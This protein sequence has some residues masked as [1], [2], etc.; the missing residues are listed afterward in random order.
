VIDFSV[1]NSLY[2]QLPEDSGIKLFR[3]DGL[4]IPFNLSWK[5]IGINLSGGADSTCL[6]TLLCKIIK[7]NSIKCEVHV[8]SYIRCWYTRPWQGPIA[9]DIYNKFV[10]DYPSISFFRHSTYI[11]PELEWGAIGPILKDEN[12]RDRSGDQIA[13]GSFNRYIMFKEKFDSIYNG[14]SANPSGQ[15]WKGGM[16]DREKSADEG[17]LKDLILIK[18]G[19]S[20]CHPF[21]FVDKSWIVRQYRNQNKLDLYN[22]TRSCEGDL[23]NSTIKNLVSN[24]ESYDP[25]IHTVDKLPKC[26]E[27]WWCKEREWAETNV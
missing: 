17:E 6:L 1:S 14:T 8:I 10:E 19:H 20:L 26:G 5:K 13:V 25:A 27:C 9:L 4:D 18:K 16:Q 7:D 24:L 23:T 3:V 12:G 2:K 22:M 21:R 15:H 11:P